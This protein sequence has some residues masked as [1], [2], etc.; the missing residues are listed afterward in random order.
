M[1]TGGYFFF[2]KWS[3]TESTITEATVGLLYLHRMIV[4]YDGCG[5][6]GRMIGR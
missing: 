4:D 1:K 6:I 5:A 3:G 2:L